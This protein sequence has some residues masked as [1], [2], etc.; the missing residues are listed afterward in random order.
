MS[1]KEK[2]AIEHCILDE[3]GSCRDI[4]M[5]DMDIQAARQIA[6]LLLQSFD[7]KRGISQAGDELAGETA[8]AQLDAE[9]L[10][11][12]NAL[13][14]ILESDKNLLSHLQLFFHWEQASMVS[15][16]FTFFP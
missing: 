5:D 15:L 1:D 16:E 7:F 2:S 6:F 12:S 9:F 4:N 10:K 11:S 3:D 8:H 14:L 13:H